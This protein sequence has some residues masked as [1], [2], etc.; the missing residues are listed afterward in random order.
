MAPTWQ[1]DSD[2]GI[3]RWKAL[4]K[5]Q[6]KKPRKTKTPLN[7]RHDANR[8]SLSFWTEAEMRRLNFRV[9]KYLEG[10]HQ[11]AQ[12]RQYAWEL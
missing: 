8:E 11:R 4:L 1:I 12:R 6:G 2:E 5:R 3:A 9:N 10:C 7:Q